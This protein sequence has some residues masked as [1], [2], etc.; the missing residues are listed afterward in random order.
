MVELFICFLFHLLNYVCLS[1]CLFVYLDYHSKKQF[2]QCY[3]VKWDTERVTLESANKEIS[4]VVRVIASLSAQL[5]T[6]R[7]NVLCIIT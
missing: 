5:F 1:I 6:A 2:I 7:R 4:P 3:T